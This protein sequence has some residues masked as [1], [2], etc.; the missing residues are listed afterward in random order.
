M[1]TITEL[2]IYPI[3]SC[4]GIKLH[5]AQLTSSGLRLADG[6]IGDREWLLV[7]VNGQFLSQRMYP[8]MALITPKLTDSLMELSAPGMAALE[9]PIEQPA[10]SA[11]PTM[12]VRVWRDTVKSWDCANVAAAWLSEFMLIPCRLV[13]FHQN[14]SRIA[15]PK[16]MGEITAPMLF[17][18]SFPLL[19]IGQGSLNDLNR[20][21]RNASRQELPMNRFRPNVV[22]DGIEPYEEDRTKS[23][24]FGVTAIR[25][26]HP[27][28]RCPVPSIDQVTGLPGPD[29]LDILKIYRTRLNGAIVFGMHAIV[30]RGAG[31][32]LKVGQQVDTMSADGQQ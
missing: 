11:A 1:Q 3:K 7:D 4:G 27:C 24:H 32:I 23:M 6:S 19:V 30:E 17:N 18:D 15:S 2:N 14:A 20:R 22:I 25:L 26:V 9:I 10:S 21:L 16:K 13:R 5:E 8:R 29:P 31:S 28:Q 12:D